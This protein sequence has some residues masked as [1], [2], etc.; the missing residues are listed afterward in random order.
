MSSYHIRNIAGFIQQGDDNVFIYELVDKKDNS[1]HYVVVD[2]NSFSPPDVSVIVEHKQIRHLLRT[3]MNNG[4]TI[5]V[6]ND[7]FIMTAPKYYEIEMN[8]EDR[9]KGLRTIAYFNENPIGSVYDEDISN[10]PKRTYDDVFELYIH[11]DNFPEYVENV[12]KKMI[13]KN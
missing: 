11:E 3:L 5:S 10:I 1:I 2:E 12:G 7:N 6:E 13:I 4:C 8:D 9:R